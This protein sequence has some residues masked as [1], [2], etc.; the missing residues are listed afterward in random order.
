MRRRARAARTVARQACPT[1]CSASR[2]RRRFRTAPASDRKLLRHAVAASEGG[3]LDPPSRAASVEECR[4]RDASP[5]SSSTMTRSTLE[6]MCSSPISDNLKLHR[7]RPRASASSM[8]LAVPEPASNDFDFDVVGR[9][10]GSRWRRR[11]AKAFKPVLDDAN[12]RSVPG[13]APISAGIARTGDRRAD[14]YRSS[15]LQTRDERW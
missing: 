6:R 3:R 10:F 7:H 2:S 9:R 13:T 8:R 12:R 15:T 14:R 11:R 1:T 4:R 5:S